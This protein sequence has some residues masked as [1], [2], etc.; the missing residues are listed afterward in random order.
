MTRSPYR[1]LRRKIGESL[2][3]KQLPLVPGVSIRALDLMRYRKQL[4]IPNTPI[5]EYGTWRQKLTSLLPLYW[6]SEAGLDNVWE[7]YPGKYDRQLIVA[8]CLRGVSAQKLP[9]VVMEFGC[10]RGHTAIQMLQTMR[11][12][13]DEA[14]LLL[15]D[16]F[17]G[18]PA[19]PHPGDAHWRAGDLTADYDEV[20]QRFAPYPQVQLI[21]GFFKETLPAFS[22]AAVKFAHVD[23]DLYISIKEVNEWLLPRMVR[24]GI[25]VYDDY[26]FSSCIGALQAVDEDFSS[27]NDFF[28]FYLPTGQFMAIKLK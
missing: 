8:Q 17:A 12:E 11:N 13:G 9:G 1:W 27:R 4:L 24:N 28:T 20:R 26:G 10:F 22:D 6:F 18:V 7:R 16:S 5:Y 14:P 3:K 15:F 2:R 19:S 21:R 23:A 25:V